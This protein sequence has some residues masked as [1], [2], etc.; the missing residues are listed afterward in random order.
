M[1]PDI[2]IK[3][4]A[5]YQSVEVIYNGKHPCE[6][7]YVDKRTRMEDVAQEFLEVL[8]ALNVTCEMVKE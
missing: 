1:N 5:Y 7:A 4:N 2:T 6:L 8:A 3:Y